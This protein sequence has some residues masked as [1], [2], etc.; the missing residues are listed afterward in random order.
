MENV[1]FTNGFEDHIEGVKSCSSKDNK[2]RWNEPR[3]HSIEK[4][5]SNGPKLDLL[6]TDF[7][8]YG[9]NNQLLDFSCSMV[10]IG[11]DFL[12]FVQGSSDATS[13]KVSDH[14]ER[15]SLNDGLHS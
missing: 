2:Q 7:G 11:K 15:V 9:P 12:D 10:Y 6:L 13:S 14:K 5:W 8:D 4:I 1:I 3:F